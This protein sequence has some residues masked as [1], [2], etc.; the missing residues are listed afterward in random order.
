MPIPFAQVDVRTHDGFR[1]TLF[2]RRALRADATPVLLLPGL[3]AN[4]FSFGIALDRSLVTALNA[5]QR[6]VWVAELRGAR[7]SEWLGSTRQRRPTTDID[8]KLS[9]DLPAC[10]DAIQD[11][12]GASQVDLVGHSLGGLLATLTAGGPHGARIRRLVTVCTPGTF[13]GFASILGPAERFAAFGVEAL[14]ERFSHVPV[15]RLARLR[16]A[17]P[18]LALLANQMLPGALT[19]PERRLF[20][21][22]AV[23][24]IPAGELAQLALWIRRRALVDRRGDSLDGRFALVTQPTLV[25]AAGR[26]RV[27]HPE[28]VK[29]GFDKLGTRQKWFTT[30]G[31][32]HGH[33]SD[34]AHCD[35][36]VGP[37]AH[38]DLYRPVAEFLAAS[39]LDLRTTR[40]AA[41]SA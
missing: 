4:R 16:G 12:T 32:A 7:S 19:A 26:D 27:C 14:A 13:D 10:L 18:H 15:G 28:R 30:I 34:Y 41:R 39:A 3:A 37:H 36:L 38:E 11:A 23:E 33:R 29:S 17:L 21:D 35:L 5:A 6:D 24:N 2:R 25:I 8:H 40:R 22:R 20:L 1:L 9:V 31:L